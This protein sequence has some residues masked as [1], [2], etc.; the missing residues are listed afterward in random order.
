MAGSGDDRRQRRSERASIIGFHTC[1]RHRSRVCDEAPQRRVLCRRV[2]QQLQ[3]MLRM[4]LHEIA[5]PC[6]V[7][8]QTSH[9]AKGVDALDEVFADHGI[10]EPALVLHR[11]RR[12]GGAQRRCEQPASCSR[13]H[14]MPRIHLDSCQTA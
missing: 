10:V 11:K 6:L 8:E 9:A 7:L 4:E 14:T 3:L 1:R 5:D 13:G 12:K 2:R